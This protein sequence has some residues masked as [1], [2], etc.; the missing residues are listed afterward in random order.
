MSRAV[1][2]TQKDKYNCTYKRDVESQST[3]V[4]KGRGGQR[5]QE[6]TF[7]GRRAL[8]DEDSSENGRWRCLQVMD[9]LNTRVYSKILFHYVLHHSEK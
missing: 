9:L 5:A 7:S 4:A 1:R 2:Q 8:Q 6:R 3:G